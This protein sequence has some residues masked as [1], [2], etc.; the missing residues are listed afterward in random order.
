MGIVPIWGF[1]MMIAV[2]VAR[3]AKLNIPLVLVAANISIPPL[4]PLIIYFSLLIG[5]KFLGIHDTLLF[6]FD[7]KQDDIELK[8]KQYVIGSIALAIMASVFFGVLT[9]VCFKIGSRKTK[10]VKEM[11]EELNS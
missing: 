3:F 6:S 9:Y 1:Q 8:L 5:A 2:V 11:M 10:G 4:I 7:L